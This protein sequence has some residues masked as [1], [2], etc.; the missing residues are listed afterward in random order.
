MTSAEK[1]LLLPTLPEFLRVL[2]TTTGLIDPTMTV[3]FAIRPAC[4][5]RLWDGYRYARDRD[6]V[7]LPCRLCKRDNE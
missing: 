2:P 4:A 7:W 1:R 3:L 6:A 5:V